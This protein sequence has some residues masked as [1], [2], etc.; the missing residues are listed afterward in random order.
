MNKSDAGGKLL[1]GPAYSGMNSKE[2]QR[3]KYVMSSTPKNHDH[4]S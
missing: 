3:A 1:N 2:D 4:N